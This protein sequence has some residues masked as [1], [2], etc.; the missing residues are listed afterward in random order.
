V[1]DDGATLHSERIFDVYSN[2]TCS[3]ANITVESN[4]V[5]EMG[6]LWAQRSLVVNH[7]GVGDDEGGLAC[8]L[9]DTLPNTSN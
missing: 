9:I 5:L 8:A 1:V 6:S 2:L 4:L 7:C 3:Q